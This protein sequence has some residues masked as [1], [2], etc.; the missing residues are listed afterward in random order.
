M[1]PK[2]D[3][4]KSYMHNGYFK[5]LKEVVHFYNTRDV[6]PTCE[7]GA[8]GEKVTCWPAPEDSTNLNKRQLGNLGLTGQ[9]EEAVVAFLKT[10]TDGYKI[11]SRD[12]GK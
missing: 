8:L 1:R 2:P 10:L 3:F 11:P 12:T 9:Q 5:N 6:L 7:P 4:V